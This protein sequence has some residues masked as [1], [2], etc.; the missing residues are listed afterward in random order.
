MNWSA[1]QPDPEVEEA[2]RLLRAQRST[3]DMALFRRSGIGGW[4]LDWTAPPRPGGYMTPLG[5]SRLRRDLHGR[6][7]RGGGTE[8]G[9]PARGDSAPAGLLPTKHGDPVMERRRDSLSARRGSAYP[10][11]HTWPLQPRRRDKA[12]A[13]CRVDALLC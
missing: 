6:R 10:N 1:N 9:T 5:R 13:F 11:R 7:A 4:W 2:A 3:G 8:M 12:Q